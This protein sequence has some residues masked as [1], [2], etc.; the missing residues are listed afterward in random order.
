M[1]DHSAIRDTA[2]YLRHVRPLD[3]DEIQTY[4]EAHPAVI[5]QVLRESAVELGLIER[6]DGTFVP[7]PDEPISPT[8]GPIEALP[9]RY[10]QCLDALLTDAFGP[11][12]PQGAS[13]DKLRQTIR[14][15]KD[16]YYRQQPVEYD[17][18]AAFGYAI[19]HLADYYAAIQYVLRE[20]T[21]AGLLPRSLRVLDVG[22]GVGGPAIGLFDAVPS[23]ALV[24]YHAIEPSDPAA[25]ILT[26][27]LENTGPN[28]HTR[29]DQHRAE[30]AHPDGPYDLI[31]FANVLSELDD[32]VAVARRYYEH[33]AADGT[34]LL[35][36]PADR[37]T[38][39]TLRTVERALVDDG[40]ATMFSPTLRLWPD[41]QPTDE[42][43]SFATAPKLAPPAAQRRLQAAAPPATDPETFLNTS[44]KY[45]YALLR[46]DGHQRIPATPDET[47]WAKLAGSDDRVGARVDLMTV[48][49]S[50][51]L[52]DTGNPLYRIG[53]GS[54]STD[55]FAV[56][57]HETALNRALQ[58]APYGAVLLIES[59]LVLW[60]ADESAYNIVIDDETV[61][62]AVE[63]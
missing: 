26:A 18:T 51:D 58:E 54:Q 41:A 62:D 29:T 31:L 63:P 48:K 44:V 4:V 56:L 17:R 46:T 22:A 27:M 28:V 23:D 36:S 42:G 61:V 7:V 10:Q 11:E 14:Q 19:Y 34:M 3:P 47:T 53:D 5:R 37:N 6:P 50:V 60:N 15:L 40:P 33:L 39:R 25:E 57:T 20:L 38:T 32:P 1:V 13:G 16:A 9:D 45:A 59:G 2:K 35:L 24:E 12:W 43:W 49:L 52:A 8:E 30:T 55:H 21:T